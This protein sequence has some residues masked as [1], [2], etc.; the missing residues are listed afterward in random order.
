MHAIICDAND[1]LSA[2]WKGVL[3]V[4]S[5]EIVKNRIPIIFDDTLDSWVAARFIT[6]NNKKRIHINKNLNARTQNFYIAFAT[7]LSLYSNKSLDL[8]ESNL[9]YNIKDIQR[10]SDFELYKKA[11]CFAARLL[12][13]YVIAKAFKP[14]SESYYYAE[15]FGIPKEF[16]NS[17]IDYYNTH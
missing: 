14:D 8:F 16:Y 3:P 4:N 15:K 9:Y 5:F 6:I 11:W 17:V 1:F 12:V 2:S 13:P 10:D 7:G